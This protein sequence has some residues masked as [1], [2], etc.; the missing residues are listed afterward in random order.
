M[1]HRHRRKGRRNRPYPRGK[2]RRQHR[3][4]DQPAC[5][6]RRH[7]GCPGRRAGTGFAV[8][9]EEVRKL[10]GQSEQAAGQIT[11][12][13]GTI[14]SDTQ[15][16][17]AAMENGTREVGAGARMV[18]AAGEAFYS[19]IRLAEEVSGRAGEISTAASRLIRDSDQTV[20]A[21]AGIRVISKDTM[22]WPR[23]RR[24]RPR[25]SRRR[26]RKSPRPAGNLPTWRANSRRR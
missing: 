7:R 21:V 6:E 2:E 22:A 13:I 15:Q 26:W 14:Q 18:N 8:V 4:P 19:I 20:R 25:N 9:A 11:A 5:L 17:V 12:L 24:R 16:V 1:R 10:A 23:R 3:R